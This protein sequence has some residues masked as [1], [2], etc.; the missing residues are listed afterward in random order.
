M[1]L[2]DIVVLCMVCAMALMLWSGRK[3]GQKNRDLHERNQREAKRIENL[4]HLD[5]HVHS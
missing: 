3:I 2:L 1:T 4:Y 5:D